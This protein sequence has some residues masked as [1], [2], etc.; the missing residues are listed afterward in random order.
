MNTQEAEN[1][2]DIPERGKDNCKNAE[3]LISKI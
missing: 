3:I 1:N 2:K